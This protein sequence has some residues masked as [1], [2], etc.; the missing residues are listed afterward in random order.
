MSKLILPDIEPESLSRRRFVTGLAAG[1]ALM[2][3]GLSATAKSA[4]SMKKILSSAPVLKGPRFDLSYSGT[5]INLTGNERVATAINGS[6]PA[7]TLRWE[8]G[9]TDTLNVT[10]NMAYDT[11]IHWHGIILPGSQNGA[12]DVSDGF[13][14][15][16]P[17]E[18]FRY[19]FP[20]IQS[21]TYC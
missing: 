13:K 7:P 3:L 21:G 15:I 6:V 5:R 11:S 19:K 12:P 4:D 20:I 10:N 9:D 2:G 16:K 8:E 18:A 1:T 17:G 14:G